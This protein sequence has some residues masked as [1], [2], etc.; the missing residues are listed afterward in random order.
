MERTAVWQIL[1]WLK[2]DHRRV[3]ATLAAHGDYTSAAGSLG[4]SYRSFASRI[5]AARK[6]FLELWHEGDRPSTRCRRTF[7]RG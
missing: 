2:P 1:A 5:S 6:A 7:P 3:I 4:T